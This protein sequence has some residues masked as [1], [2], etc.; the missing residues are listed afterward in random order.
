KE[1]LRA[2]PM[3][4]LHWG[5]LPHDGLPKADSGFNYLGRFDQSVERD[6][7]FSF[8]RESGGRSLSGE[9][10]LDHALEINGS[11]ANGCLSLSWRY[12]PAVM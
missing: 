2:V 4:G 5:L 7:L 9:T 6:G 10:E 1:A 3:K 12:S 8:S 11:I